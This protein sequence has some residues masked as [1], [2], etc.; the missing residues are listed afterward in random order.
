M[1]TQNQG[2]REAELYQEIYKN[3]T[4]GAEALTDIIDRVG[5][6]D[7]KTELGTELAGYEKLASEARQAL[8]DMGITPREQSAVA[9]L[10]AKAGMA[11]NTMMDS[12]TSHLAQMTIKG[13]TM[14]T[15][16]LLRKINEFECEI[17]EGGK[18]F[19]NAVDLARRTVDFEED[20]IEKLKAYL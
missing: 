15:T 10:S 9:K 17:K 16:D 2:R 18:E 7:L 8:F 19:Q 3:V 6:G 12:T 1:T 11:M 4:M 5:D 14:G 13:S 20:C